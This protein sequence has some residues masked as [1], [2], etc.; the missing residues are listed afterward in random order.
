MALQFL[1]NKIFANKNL[2]YAQM[3]NGMY[4]VFSQFGE[5]IF[6]SDVVQQGLYAIVTEMK[7]LRPRHIR[8]DGFDLIPVFDDLQR[9]LDQPNPLMTRS[10][11][12]E[13]VTWSVLLNYN[14]FIYI[15]R[16]GD[17][18]TALYPLNPQTV[19]FLQSPD[20]KMYL[21]MQFRN[22]YAYTLPYENFI[23]IKTH[24][25]FN[26]FM[27]G[28]QF[29]QPNNRALLGTLELNHALLEGVR[30]ALNT[31][32]SING[33]IKYNTLLDDGKMEKNIKEFE[34][35]IAN[36]QSGFLGTD[37]KAEIV[38]FKRE[39]KI[40][41]NDTLKFIDDKI[42]RHIGTPIEIVRG[43]Y[44]TDQYQAF[45]QKTL[46]PL[47]INFS[48]AFTKALFTTRE[49]GFE[50]EIV[51]YPRELIFLNTAQTIE[52]V[53]LLGD[54][55]ALYDNEARVAFGLEPLQELKGRRSQS[56]NYVDASIAKQYQL[57]LEKDPGAVKEV[58]V[59]KD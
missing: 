2:R 24:Y 21:E 48:E 11:F 26:D 35:K 49:I 8:R 4:P 22:G 34:Q 6:A 43:D 25:A 18:V 38:P 23:H 12:I 16:D 52:M 17:K 1:K 59:D 50:N 55:G 41:D 20:G 53:R 56:L 28:D 31:S 40:V 57:N 32:F 30:K 54:R 3:L 29:G 45:Y 15:E 47:V 27:G 14:A 10:D 7:K 5:D 33:I 36:S 44:T 19:S 46:E 13:R 42:L 39:I 9:V 51:F 58:V 37:L